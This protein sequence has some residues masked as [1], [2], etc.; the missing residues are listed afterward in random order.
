MI[1][2]NELR[3][4]N[5]V[6]HSE[7]GRAY[8]VGEILK[9]G[10]RSTYIREDTGTEHTSLISY[11]CIDGILLTP[12]ILERC[13]FKRHKCGISGADM[14]QGMD[15]WSINNPLFSGWLFRGDG[16]Y[17][18]LTGYFNSDIKYLHQLQNL[19]FALTNS[20]LIINL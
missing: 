14:W 18:R 20:E 8:S 15:G 19:Y 9:T 3:I 13:G 2:I 16:K 1:Q 4:G 12:E 6:K 7:T 5:I 11:D 17:L 10:I